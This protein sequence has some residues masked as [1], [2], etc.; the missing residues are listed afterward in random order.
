MESVNGFAESVVDVFVHL[1]VI[2]LALKGLV[3][4]VIVMIMV[5]MV[6]IRIALVNIVAMDFGIVGVALCMDVIRVSLCRGSVEVIASA[7]D[8]RRN[9]RTLGMEV[10]NRELLEFNSISKNLISLFVIAFRSGRTSEVVPCSS[11]PIALH[12][13]LWM[14]IPSS[15]LLEFLGFGKNLISLF[16]VAFRSRRASEVVPRSSKTIALDRLLRIEVPA[17]NFLELLSFR[18]NAVA[19]LF[20][21]LVVLG[22]RRAREE[23]SST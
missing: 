4:D 7:V 14:E 13:L 3:R 15:N 22:S 8:A 17:C 10:V 11:E 5:V 23:V 21:L 18:Q 1:K 20:H 9:N 6:V 19:L 12:W 16:V 2:A